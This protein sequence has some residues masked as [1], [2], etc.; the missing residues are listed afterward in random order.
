MHHHLS[1]RGKLI[2]MFSVMASLFL[3][4]LDQTII[5]TALGKIVEEFNAYDSLSW[6]VTAYLLTTTATVPIAGKLS[7]LFGRRKLLLIGVA[8]FAAGSLFS[9]YADSIG[10]L[11]GAR[12]IQGIGGGIITANAF[13]IIGDLFSPRE[14]GKWQGLFGAVFAISSLIG[15][16]LGGYLTDGNNLLGFTTNWRWA[17]LINIPVGMVAFILIAIYSPRL[18]NPARPKI[19]YRGAAL[20][21]V[22]LS[23]LVLA[24]DNTASVFSGVMET[25]NLSLVGL[26]V[27][28]ALVVALAIG[29]FILVERRAPQP[30]LPLHFFKNSNY[31]KII[32][33]A[34]L[35]GSAFLGLVIY[36]TQFNQQVFAATPTQSGLMLL[37]MIAGIM[38]TSVG[39]GQIISRTGRYKLFMQVG[40]VVAT[41][42]IFT[43]TTLSPDSTYAYE[44]VLIFIL[45]TGLGI[46]MPVMNLAVQNEFEQ[47]D[48]GAATSSNQLFRSLGSTIGI[49]IFGA[50]LTAGITTSLNQSLNDDQYIK[51]LSSNAQVQKVGNLEDP[52]TQLT[53][54]MPDVKTKITNS[55]EA[56]ISDLQPDQKNKLSKD[57]YTAQNAYSAK[58]K[59]AFSTSLRNIF[60]ISTILMFAASILVFTLKERE[61]KTVQPVVE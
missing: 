53:L 17:F 54:N 19:D 42:M 45:G 37:P 38:I 57:F 20:L 5:S 18:K 46:V 24:V 2:I 26:R 10:M 30:I 34:T 61:L 48:L 51:A 8:I 28:M 52:N 16:L 31:T 21:T 23:T 4:A 7:D 32:A 44:A 25:L 36:L 15:P 60:Y 40:I 9:G 56:S 41:I 22:A 59:Q 12:A 13:T 27:I 49:A 14:R 55:F 3:V 58:I 33:I 47:S 50:I 39:G 6:I 35:F 1:L 29:A 11:I 43:L